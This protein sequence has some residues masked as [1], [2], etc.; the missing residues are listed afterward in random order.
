MSYFG[1]KP[2]KGRK[3][4]VAEVPEDVQL[5]DPSTLTLAGKKID[6]IVLALLMAGADEVDEVRDSVTDAMVNLGMNEPDIVL[7]KIA[8]FISK[9]T[10]MKSRH[11]MCLLEATRHLC[12]RKGE[13]IEEETASTVS[14]VCIT[15]M[16]SDKDGSGKTEEECVEILRL[17]AFPFPFV[18]CKKLEDQIESGVA[19]RNCIVHALGTIANNIP[20]PFISH[21]GTILKRMVPVLGTIKQ[22]K[23]MVL[24]AQSFG[25]FCDA[26]NF[27]ETNV[28]EEKKEIN[29]TA[30]F[31]STMNS[32][33]D[34]LY[35]RWFAKKDKDVRREVAG[36]LAQVSTFTSP[37][38]LSEAA[39]KLI[40]V[41]LDRYKKE[42]RDR[43]LHITRPFVHLLHA[44]VD[45]CPDALQPMYN[46][47]LV[48]FHSLAVSS[49][50]IDVENPDTLRLFNEILFALEVLGAHFTDDLL[51]LL[52]RSLM[53]KDA[54]VRSTTLL[55]YRHLVSR[56]P[57]VLV[58][59]KDVVVSALRLM[60]EEQDIAVRMSFVQTLVSLAGAKFLDAEGS[61][62]LLMVIIRGVRISDET[63][64]QH[65]QNWKR[66]GGDV[67]LLR[68]FRQTCESVLTLMASTVSGSDDFLWPFLAE[69]IPKV[70]LSE[71]IGVI[72]K[73]TADVVSKRIA[74]KKEVTI[75]SVNMPQPEDLFARLMV[76]STSF[77][78]RNDVP[79]EICRLLAALSDVFFL[80]DSVIKYWKKFV[81]KFLKYLA[82]ENFDD[83][84]FE[85]QIRRFVGETAR[86]IGDEEIVRALAFAFLRQ[87]VEGSLDDSSRYT[88]F[89][90]LGAVVKNM[91]HRDTVANMIQ[92]SYEYCRF[93]EEADRRGLAVCYGEMGSVHT[94]VVL[95][96]V[97]FYM[98]NFTAPSR[99]SG[100]KGVVAAPSADGA[101]FDPS[102]PA[103]AQTSSPPP[104]KGFF[105]RFKKSSGSSGSVGR[106]DPTTIRSACAE[107]LGLI[108]LHAP[109]ALVLSRVD[110]HVVT[111]LMN[112]LREGKAHSERTHALR[113]LIVVAEALRPDNIE[114]VDP[115]FTLKERRAI[116]DSIMDLLMSMKAGTKKLEQNTELITLGMQALRKLYDLPPVFAQEDRE[117]FFDR[118]I[119]VFLVDFQDEESD[120][121]LFE[122]A[123]EMLI[124]ILED[125]MTISHFTFLLGAIYRQYL[126]H[127]SVNVRNRASYCM[128]QMIKRFARY[129][130]EN[131]GEFSEKELPEYGRLIS[132]FLPRCSD[133]SGKIR[134]NCMESI[135]LLLRIE[136]F[137]Q[138]G[139]KGSAP[140]ALGRFQELRDTIS[141]AEQQDL[142][143]CVKELANVVG[144]VVDND[145]MVRLFE[146]LI[147]AMGDHNPDCANGAC[148]I[149]ST[150]GRT[151]TDS[152]RPALVGLVVLLQKRMAHVAG[153]GR[154]QTLKGG[155][156]IFKS[157]AELDVVAVSRVLLEQPTPHPQYV[158]ESLQAIATN[159]KV[160]KDLLQYLSD[161]L[162]NTQLYEEERKNVTQEIKKNTGEAA[163]QETRRK[164]AKPFPCSVTCAIEEI[165]LSPQV[166]AAAIEHSSLLVS[167]LC[168]RIGTAF[169]STEAPRLMRDAIKAL[170]AVL[171]SMGRADVA[172]ELDACAI[173]SSDDDEYLQPVMT[174]INGLARSH[175]LSEA[176]EDDNHEVISE[177]Y[178]FNFAFLSRMYVGQVQVATCIMGCLLNCLNVPSPKSRSYS[179]GSEL[180]DGIANALLQKTGVD[181]FSG[182][183]VQA[184]RGLGHISMMKQMSSELAKTDIPRNLYAT[185]IISAL[186]TSVD[187][188]DD[189]VA[190]EA[191]ESMAGIFET[192]EPRYVTPVLVNVC[193]RIRL[194]FDR[195]DDAVR[196]SAFRLFGTFHRFG[197]PGKMMDAFEEQLHKNFP[198]I[199]IHCNDDAAEV[200]HACKTGLRLLAPLLGSEK[201]VDM[202]QEKFVS[203]EYQ[204]DF[205]NFSDQ[206]AQ[207]FA[208]DLKD[209]V[210]A[211]LSGILHYLRHKKPVLRQAAALICGSMLR[212]L[213]ASGRAAVNTEQ[214]IAY[215]IA[216]LKDPNPTVRRSVSDAL[217]HLHEY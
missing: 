63:I 175:A 15:V 125:D 72:V 78:L 111:P 122:S 103:P 189:S 157:L 167:T 184:L 146:G 203:P 47:L 98:T 38:E 118:V 187:D 109:I 132:W 55:I 136:Y 85:E 156:H 179:R 135:Y 77:H 12:Q 59:K 41:F 139:P 32:V 16:L 196:A 44:I 82:M 29:C 143:I 62:E 1:A 49:S 126:I 101:T 119:P 116:M 69:M 112:L 99:V 133:T 84:V 131:P 4:P 141:E 176:E 174:V 197:S 170:S 5:P 158:V 107:A 51:L 67:D 110:I 68:Q 17:L 30:A 159:Q 65:E 202:T 35:T 166:R 53:H 211:L 36:A 23:T 155:Y 75:R 13:I 200:R 161:S 213:P 54:Q 205:Q 129:M 168:M 64:R 180:L 2:K 10:G 88:C 123:S 40:P 34:I 160:V 198:F 89:G 26:I 121:K 93:W 105:S 42:K 124:S 153:L 66:K 7:D 60:V 58:T 185:P 90:L 199:V 25:A 172:A 128:N 194:C 134:S 145:E 120:E 21:L 91:Q 210:S 191:M 147:F 94:D 57:A 52:Q 208:V 204:M 104:K 22:E 14:G 150:L 137:L 97:R 83:T 6:D 95:E 190:F 171:N 152:L 92:F 20:I 46:V 31:E 206:F 163:Y 102:A 216:Q 9:N 149:M 80:N 212:Y 192:V 50:H 207:V 86:H 27:Y 96:K 215:L 173:N 61:Q 162:N 73:C 144:A 108:A 114:S 178:E 18:V 164:P 3:A 188:K 177:L 74:A 165:F 45:K 81:P 115:D 193:L 140:D 76:H 28:E 209:R 100:V 87:L 39:G 127:A 195:E 24:F 11:R 148:V 70:E 182:I 201:L 130:A 113:G 138:L 186:M 43:L 181:E 214:V 71:G 106:N 151:H 169:F 117:A 33:F 48:H 8:A 37:A 19:P 142:F 154:P 183:R 217:G 79:R 56:L